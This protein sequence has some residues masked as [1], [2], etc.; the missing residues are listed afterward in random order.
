MVEDSRKTFHLDPSNCLVSFTVYRPPD[1]SPGAYLM[2][3]SLELSLALSSTLLEDIERKAVLAFVENL[4]KGHLLN[5]V[6]VSSDRYC[7]ALA[8][9]LGIKRLIVRVEILNEPVPSGS[10][11]PA[12][13]PPGKTREQELKE[14]L[15]SLSDAVVNIVNAESNLKDAEAELERAFRGRSEAEFDAYAAKMKLAP[16]FVVELRQIWR[17]ANRT[18]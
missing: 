5:G 3:S 11:E 8:D 9:A 14:N 2:L 17:R 13:R 6:D 18:R 4:L 7:T 15:T 10:R 1:G 16:E 12:K